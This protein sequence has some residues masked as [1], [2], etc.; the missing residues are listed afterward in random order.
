MSAN[1]EAGSPIDGDVPR[2]RMPARHAV[3]QQPQADSFDV[4][5]YSGMEL[6]G[7]DPS[8]A[9]AASSAVDEASGGQAEPVPASEDDDARSG[10]FGL[11][12]ILLRKGPKYA[13]RI[14]REHVER[15]VRLGQR[16]SMQGCSVQFAVSA[17]HAHLHV[18]L[19]VMI[20][21][22]LVCSAV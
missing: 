16:Q 18:Q 9:A 11:C 3:Q 8:A 14:L 10:W 22:F 21:V 2:R 20:I 6:S 12:E 4:N 19:I 1:S 5:G 13:G 7:V 17:F 15:S